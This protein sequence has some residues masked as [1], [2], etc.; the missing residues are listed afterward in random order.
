ILTAFQRIQRFVEGVGKDA[1]KLRGLRVDG[2]LFNLMT[3][4]EAN[5][6]IPQEEQDK[7]PDVRW[8]DISRF[9]D[10][11]VHHYFTLDLDIVWEIVQEHLPVLA[12]NVEEM[13]RES[14]EG[15]QE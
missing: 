4:G 13:S 2:V 5:K 3:I 10:R 6:R 15:N 1:F 14:N 7:Y 8:K 12:K 11:V 9:R